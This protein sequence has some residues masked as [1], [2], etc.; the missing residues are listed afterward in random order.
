MSIFEISDQLRKRECSPVEITQ[1]CLRR[2]EQLNP[3]LNAF[4]TV[5]ADSAL[6]EARQAEQEI[7]S[8]NYRGLLHGIPIA[9][10]DLIDTSGVRTTAASALF[11]R[12][13]PTQDAELVSRLKTAGAIFLG[14][15]N[16]HEF[17]YG[18][19]SVVSHFGP[20]RNPWNPE[21]I[22]GGSSGGSAAAVSAELCYASIGTDTAGSIREPAAFCGV[23]GLKP[24]Y[25]LVSA[26]G[27]IPLS[28][29][30]DHVGPLTRSVADAAL[31]MQVLSDASNYLAA[32]KRGLGEFSIGVP[33]TFFYEE[34]DPE[35]S[36]AM[37]AALSTF[38]ELGFNLCDVSLAV[39]TDRT[40][41][42]AET[43][44]Y[45]R[46]WIETSP[47]AYQPETLRRIR[48]GAK[49]TAGEYAKA[50][51]DLTREREQIKGVFEKLDALITPTCP[52]PPVEIA[53]LQRNPERLRPT[54]LVILRNTRPFNVWGLPAIS[55]PCGFTQSGMPVGLQIA[56][57]AGR[58]D[59]VL[60][61]AHA[62]Q[63]ATPWHKRKPPLAANARRSERPAIC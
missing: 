12:R 34:I 2:I 58:E 51:R 62:Y 3:V 52:V 19:S 42:M 57:S 40:L 60:A 39:N 8:G 23:V 49:V 48:A 35:V 22:S 17:A 24:T 55:V 31:V 9:L 28:L 46:E 44:S 10:K 14:K 53:E 47:E 30:L 21:Y 5:T 59:V 43:Y 33:R 26:K 13:V 20:A 4:I 11:E 56:A 54:E 29:S 32:I 61:L 15:N 27:V 50:K 36:R 6:A 25:G 7:Q 45:H 16:L 63:Q 37:E 1:E 18:G 41:Q 38:R